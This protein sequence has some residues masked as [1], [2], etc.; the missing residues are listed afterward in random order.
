M[1]SV[2]PLFGPDQWYI[3]A[4]EQLVVVIRELSNAKTLS[5]VTEIVRKAARELTGA[6]GATFV[7]KDGE[8]CYYADENAI[9]PL[10]KGQRFPLKN[11][12]SGWAM[13]NK[14]PAIIEDIYADSRVPTEAYRPT[15]VKSMVMVPIRQSDPI[16]AIGNYWARVRQP[17][18]E[19]ITILQTLAD[20]TAVAIENAHLH[21][22]LEQKSR[23][24]KNSHLAMGRFAWISSHDLQA[25][26]RAIDNIA[27]WIEESLQKRNYDDAA[28]HVKSLH[29]RVERMGRLLKDILAYAQIDYIIDPYS[30]AERINGELLIRDAIG[31]L[32]VPKDFQI[33]VNGGF[34]HISLPRM[35]LQQIFFNLLNNA[36][37]HNNKRNG[38]VSVDC[39]EREKNYLFTVSDNGPGIEY[40]Q[41]DKI[42]EMFQSPK[43]S[44]TKGRGGMGL[45][46]V[47]KIL[48][49]HDSDITV[50]SVPGRGSIFRFTWPKTLKD[51]ATIS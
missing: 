21:D 19:E 9:S 17:T 29:G 45:A 40:A 42:F 3:N 4:M 13:L 24:L 30:N 8:Y 15:F 11:C 22:Q 33:D 10:W 50:E 51:E 46:L 48:N 43:Q 20:V 6:D 16:G 34:S 37:V 28:E 39:E 47:K 35:P 7:L 41:Q 26:L 5:A 36:I 32:D 1:S 23:A 27:Q 44:E 31:L 49:V 18:H 2:V 38:M 25:P 14:Q 12:V